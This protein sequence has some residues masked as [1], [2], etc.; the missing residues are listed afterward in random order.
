[1]APN[2]DER[3]YNIEKLNKV[4]AISALLLLAGVGLLFIKDYSREW[5]EF[6]KQ[7][8]I[9]EVEQARV[10]YD[11]ALTDLTKNPEYQELETKLIAAKKDQQS[12]CSSLTHVTADIKDL[13]AKKDIADQKYKFSKAQ[14]D[15]AKY[16]YEAKNSAHS[17]DVNSAK[18][19]L[20]SDLKKTE[21]LKRSFESITAQ[22]KDKEDILNACSEN[23][24]E[25]E[26]KDRQLAK[27]KSLFERKLKK[28]DPNQM[29]F[30]NQIA[31]MFRDMP[32]IDLANPSLKI[33]QIVL[34]DIR[35]DVNFMNVPRVD[36]CVSCHLGIA[37][38]DFKDFPQ[39]YKTHSNLKLILDP[40]SAHP[41]EDFG[42]TVCHG[43]RGRGT[44]FNAAIHMPQNEKQKE[45]WIKKY[46]WHHNE[47]WEDPML[48]LQYVEAGCFK[49]HSGETT[50]KGAEKLNLGLNLIEKTGCYGCHVIDK[51]KGWPKPGPDLRKL[52]SKSSKEWTYK[53]ILDPKSFR[54]NT[55]MPAFFNQS[56]N[57]DQYSQKRSEQEIHA[58][59]HY[60]FSKNDKY[61]LV[62]T[63]ATADIQNG[64]KIVS[65]LGCLACHQIQKE[66]E[67][68]PLTRD[69]L[70]QQHGPNLIGLGTKTSKEWIFNWLKDPNR[71]HPETKMPNLRLNDQE[72][73]D[74]A[75]FLAVD[76]NQ[77]FASKSIPQVDENVLNT[78]VYDF[79]KKAET[80]KNTQSK[81][82]TMTRDQKLAFAGE[83]LIGS[84]GCYGCHAISGFETVKPIGT[85]LSQEGLKS[86]HRLDFALSDIEK[87]RHAFFFQ[88]LKEPRLF[89]KGKIKE[90]LEK[91]IM[92]NFNLSDQEAEALV[93]A[94]LGFVDQK[95]VANKIKPR[96]PRNLMIE[97]GQKIVRQLNCQGC[98]IIDGEGGTISKSIEQW[99][100]KYDNRSESEAVSMIPSFSPPNLVGEGAK[101][102]T[103]WLFNF[104]HQPTSIR[105][106]LKTRMPTYA[107]NAAHLNVIVKY[108]SVLDNQE[109]PFSDHVNTTLNDSELKA[110]EKLFSKDYFGCTQC[111][112]VGD[113]MPSGS[114]DSW[115]PN[116]ELAK[117]RL[118]PEWIIEWLKNPADLL[119]GT[120]MPTYFDPKNFDTSGPEDVLDGDEKEQIRVLR[121][122]LMTISE[123]PLPADPEQK[124]APVDPIPGDASPETKAK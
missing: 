55:W 36:R 76:Q 101:V 106:W 121:N 57:N 53:W 102:Q 1:M 33:E 47:E 82:K 115:A 123:H 68:G 84:Y 91:L 23:F 34:K 49:C 83:K 70:R 40:N 78:I 90:P 51:Y 48:P 41:L 111:H 112:I 104:L 18:S 26:K 97:D 80:E 81:I 58:I 107:F 16:R 85:D 2:P 38:P 66:P 20:D 12:K 60:L 42:C 120:K 17:S 24:K 13:K 29:T 15:A 22:L 21:D 25:L 9:Y 79:L 124:P 63:A 73:I 72:A 59:V 62:N 14:L 27:Q 32:F 8:H 7:F 74:V 50:I 119:P 69:R 65:S 99:L 39:P 5:K 87:T 108:F 116:F 54:H 11:K 88:K 105:P 44:S 96:T 109:F 43:G 30:L 56:N 64:E 10:K 92:P 3:H 52:A 93:T 118:K 94:I 19:E 31:N 67:G 71:Y 103:E 37:N 110:A 61:D 6:Q 117:S 95:L 113:K 98:H 114:A 35:E 86:V 4:F 100:V 89:D 28:I 75:E 45:E 77:S 122:F 46:H